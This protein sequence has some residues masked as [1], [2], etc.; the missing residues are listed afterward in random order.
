MSPVAAMTL[1]LVVDLF[2][3]KRLEVTIV[4]VRPS[5]VNVFP[6]LPRRTGRAQSFLERARVE[7]VGRRRRSRFQE[8]HDRNALRLREGVERSSRAVTRS[9]QS[10]S[11]HVPARSRPLNFPASGRTLLWIYRQRLR[12]RAS[13]ESDYNGLGAADDGDNRSRRTIE[14]FSRGSHARRRFQSL[15]F[16]RRA[17]RRQPLY[18]CV[19]S[20]GTIVEMFGMPGHEARVH[21]RRRRLPHARVRERRI[22][23]PGLITAIA[24]A[25]ARLLA[26]GARHASEAYE[27]HVTART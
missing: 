10:E 3:G 7:A 25:T 12:S 6:L 8:A 4:V 18:D 16:G 9:T 27:L 11:V 20:L 15:R 21:D 5:M 2:T 1:T 24:R 26:V 17:A 19:V 14:P 13:R 22:P 23:R